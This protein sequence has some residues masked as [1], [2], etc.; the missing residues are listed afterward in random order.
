MKRTLSMLYLKLLKLKHFIKSKL[1]KNK[2]IYSLDKYGLE[3]RQI[4]QAFLKTLNPENNPQEKQILDM[5]HQYRADLSADTRKISFEEIGSTTKMTVAEVA[6]RAASPEVWTRFFYQLSKPNNINNIL[7]IGTN[8]GVSGQYFLKALEGKKNTKF[9]TLEGVKGLCDIAKERL[10]LLS[11]EQEFEV[12]H[13][14]YDQT[15]INLVNKEILYDLLFIDGNHRY[16]ATLKYFELLKNNIADRALVV[17]DD[18]HWSK[19]MR[20]A[21]K[22]I[23]AQRG[24]VFSVNFFKLGMIVFDP[25]QS[26]PTND[27]F[28]LFLSL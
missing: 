6:K 14:L 26:E 3:G 15:L 1:L 18:I 7:E 16:D 5:L 20:K 13:G 17:F 4:A 27:H 19:G 24:V 11:T 23:I 9:I 10:T 8:L 12:V 21:W 25:K 2:Y 22:E 28:E